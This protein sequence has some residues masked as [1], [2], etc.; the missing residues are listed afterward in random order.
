[1][2]V[3]FAQPS[4]AQPS[5][6]NGSA[7]PVW[8]AAQQGD[9]AAQN[10][11]GDIYYLGQS[12]PRDYTQAMTWYLKAAQ[13]GDVDAQRRLGDIYSMGLGVP[14]DYAQAAAW[15]RKSAEQGD[16]ESQW[17]LGD[18]YSGGRGVSQQAL[19]WFLKSAKQGNQYAQNRVMHTEDAPTEKAVGDMYRDGVGVARDDVQAAQYYTQSAYQGNADAEAALADMYRQ[20][21]GVAQNDDQAIACY[22]KAAVQ[23]NQGAKAA[24]AEMSTPAPPM[25]R[26]VSTLP[27][28]AEMQH[29]L[30]VFYASYHQRKHVGDDVCG[31][32]LLF[33]NDS[34][35]QVDEVSGNKIKVINRFESKWINQNAIGLCSAESASVKSR[36]FSSNRQ[37][38]LSQAINAAFPGLATSTEEPNNSEIRKDN[39]FDPC[40]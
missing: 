3:G 24:L 6:D 20:G 28:S 1:M 32:T 26:S 14:K 12:V 16:P 25:A 13:Q 30:R 31:T 11:L 9:A 34:D 8:Q 37:Q 17:K 40:K 22:R 2:F 38:A 29:D 7:D 36:I 27:E 10:K 15:Y 19:A 39:V 21:K 33:S 5:S 23:G 18:M 35:G 4:P